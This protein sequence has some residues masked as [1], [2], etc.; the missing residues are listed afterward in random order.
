MQ[1]FKRTSRL[2]RSLKGR[3]GR[4]QSAREEGSS[5]RIRRLCLYERNGAVSGQL[6]VGDAILFD[7]IY[8][9]ASVL[10]EEAGCDFF[11]LTS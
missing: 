7:S 6:T 1:H 11:K 10:G 3:S 8:V 4:P 2:A 9:V 5:D